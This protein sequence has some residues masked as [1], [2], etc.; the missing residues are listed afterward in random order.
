MMYLEA[1]G[2]GFAITIGVE[3]ALGV[4]FAIGAVFKGASKNEK[5]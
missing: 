4:C 2:I 1:L 5:H 3:I